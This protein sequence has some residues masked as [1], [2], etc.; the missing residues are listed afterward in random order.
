MLAGRAHLLTD[1]VSTQRPS[2]LLAQTQCFWVPEMRCPRFAIHYGS[3]PTAYLRS[4]LVTDQGITIDTRSPQTASF[5]IA[6][7]Y[8]SLTMQPLRNTLSFLPILLLICV[9]L[10][11][12]AAPWNVEYPD[13]SDKQF[14]TSQRHQHPVE[15]S[16]GFLRWLPQL[17]W[18]RN[19][20]IDTLLR[21]PLTLPSKTE[22]PTA[23]PST[24]KL[25]AKLLAHMAE[26]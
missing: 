8:V 14:A 10:Q 11:A 19:T 20:G 3:V 15:P 6:R 12:F 4:S 1:L 9:P 21:N 24:A 16:R 26:M 22:R 25:P 23:L 7:I 5:I 18:L 2:L 17:T 13:T